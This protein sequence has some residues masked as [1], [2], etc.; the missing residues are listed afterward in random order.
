MVPVDAPE[1]A[2][3]FIKE[4]FLLLFFFLLLNL[5]LLLFVFNHELISL[6]NSADP[7]SEFI[8]I[9]VL[10]EVM[11][12]CHHILLVEVIIH[13][14]ALELV[15]LLVKVV[16][17]ATS[18][19]CA[20]CFDHRVELFLLL[21]RLLLVLL[22]RLLLFLRVKVVVALIHVIFIVEL[23]FRLAV[24]NSEALIYEVLGRRGYLLLV[25]VFNVRGLVDILVDVY[26]VVFL[27]FFHPRVTQYLVH[28]KSL[29]WFLFQYSF[30]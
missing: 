15:V 26:V 19:G 13:R 10:V 14:F 1:S 11:T 2:E 8:V 9:Q 12:L 7:L 17:V 24:L 25:H 21:N 30:N 16:A 23:L 28:S 4:S 5:F 3:D 6:R 20:A 29:L 27:H 22:L 18:R